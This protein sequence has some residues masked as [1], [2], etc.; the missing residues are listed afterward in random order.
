MTCERCNCFC[1]GC[2]PRT[3][4]NWKEAITLLFS[5]GRGALPSPQKK[6]R[7]G[8]GESFLPRKKKEFEFCGMEEKKDGQV[9]APPPLPTTGWEE[10]EK[11]QCYALL[12]SRKKRTK[13]K[14][15]N[16]QK[17]GPSTYNRRT[18]EKGEIENVLLLSR[19]GKKTGV[20]SRRERK[21]TTVC[22]SWL[23][24]R[25]KR[26]GRYPILTTPSGK[27]KG[28]G[29]GHIGKKK[30]YPTIMHATS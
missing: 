10:K 30:S 27:E 23:T 18:E 7:G 17:S 15:Q 26:K 12:R 16:P 2:F 28:G 9:R 21:I 13:K 3:T 4:S 29:G 22:L 8:L 24:L 25:G 20:S 19:K 1:A 14:T 5:E 11:R 6:G